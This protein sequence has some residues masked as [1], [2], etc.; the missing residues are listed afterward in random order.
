MIADAIKAVVEG[1]DLSSDE[2]EAAMDAVLEGNA[3]ASQ[4]AAFVVALRMK[5]ESAAE[6]AA[7]ARSLRKHCESIR[8]EVDGPLLDTCGTGGDGLHTF[9]ISTAAAV[10]AAASG[11]AVAKHGNRAVSSKAGS[12]DVLEA[13]GVRIDVEPAVVKRCIEEVGIGFLFAPSHHAAMR[14]AG[15]VRRELGIRTIFNLLG[16][17]TNPAGVE[18]QV[19]GVWGADV[20]ALM[21]AALA[22]L[23]A[24]HALVVHSEDGLESRVQFGDG[25]R[26]PVSR[27]S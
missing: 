15:P 20:Q 2:V 7:A 25:M 4:I 26:R 24:R 6:I 3:S 17:L 12:A 18:R 21:A 27:S 8:P 22:D 23:G 16:P 19:I 9:N 5:G 10:V 13:L 11:I 14:H 1:R